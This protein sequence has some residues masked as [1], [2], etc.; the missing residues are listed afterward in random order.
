MNCEKCGKELPENETLCPFCGE[1]EPVAEQVEEAVALVEET[2]VEEETAEDITE[3][4]EEA[5]ETDELE[6]DE[7]EP[8]VIRLKRG[9][10][11]V[12][13]GIIALVIAVA[14]G[15]LSFL[16]PVLIIGQWKANDQIPISADVVVQRETTMEFTLSGEMIL[17]DHIVNHE[18]IGYPA[19][20]A[21]V[22]NSFSYIFSKN[23]LLLIPAMQGEQQMPQEP[24]TMYC[25]ATPTMFSYWMQDTSPRQVYDFNRAGWLYP[26]MYLW[27]ATLVLLIL[28][29]L[30][31][32]IPGKKCIYDSLEDIIAEDEFNQ[33][34]DQ[35][36]DEIEA[37]FEEEDDET[38]SEETTE[39]ATDIP[40]TIEE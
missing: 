16:K 27:M 23:N 7:A 36:S 13:I 38:A 9:K 2:D 10:A 22:S 6:T 12:I 15:V 25:S 14:L 20:K 29:V 30:L 39:E 40:E 3:E 34:L 11:R 19:D 28:G 24:I 33:L 21:V 17:T 37:D 1:E 5:D 4:A 32:A 35:I 26:S 8:I 18:E 31:V